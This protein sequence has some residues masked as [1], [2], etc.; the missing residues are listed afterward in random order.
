MYVVLKARS[1][2]TEMERKVEKLVDPHFI[3]C[4]DAM[5]F[6]FG[7]SVSECSCDDV[8]WIWISHDL[9]EEVRVWGDFDYLPYHGSLSAVVPARLRL[10]CYGG[11]REI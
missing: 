7:R 2:N 3:P 4:N 6:F 11:G 10:L 8:Y 9:P 1:N 5:P